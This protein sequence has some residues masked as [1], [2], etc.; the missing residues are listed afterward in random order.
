MEI[1]GNQD[2][3]EFLV[4]YHRIRGFNLQCIVETRMGGF[5]VVL[6]DGDQALVDDVTHFRG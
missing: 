5:E 1:N 6:G 2:N 4:Y 3:I